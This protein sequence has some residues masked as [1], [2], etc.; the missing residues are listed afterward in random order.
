MADTMGYFTEKELPV[1]HSLAKE[2]AIIDSWFASTPGPTY[3]NRH[4]IHAA[5]AGG[6]TNS[7]IM[8]F[9]F[10][11]KTI[12]DSLNEAGR[13][14][15][16][17][18]SGLFRDWE[19]EALFYRSMWRPRNIRRVKTISRFI[20]DAKNGQLPE[21][22]F[23]EPNFKIDDM[24]PPHS[25]KTA[26]LFVKQIYEALRVSRHWNNSL[27][28]LTFDE[29]GGFYDHVSSPIN[30]PIPDD[31]RVKPVVGNF[32][33]DRLGVRV[34]TLVISPLV[35]K[36]SVIRKQPGMGEFEHSSIPATIKKVFGLPSFLTRRDAWAATF[37]IAVTRDSPRT[38]CLEKLPI[39]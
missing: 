29:H 4:F 38:D 19:V 34:P 24:H 25:L 35:E 39:P 27:M 20:Q 17:Y 26:E 11:F 15:K 7:M 32:K 21:Y 3:P 5:T 23:I 18:S 14:W 31:S 10:A 30:V 9:G 36:G 8:P 28:L 1:I 12:Y 22:S 6:W 33:F 37:D 16:V 2:Y 13:S